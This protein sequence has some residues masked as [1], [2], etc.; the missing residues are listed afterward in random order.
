MDTMSPAPWEIRL[1]S[2]AESEEWNDFVCRR[3]RNA[4]FLFDRNYMDYHADR[5][6][7]HSMMAYRGGKLLALLPANITP[8][9]ILHSHQ[10][11]TYGGWVTSAA[12]FD[13]NDMM[14]MWRVWLDV[15]RREGIKGVDYKPLPWIFARF[16]AQE[17]L[18]M[19][20]R[21]GACLTES[22]LS[23]AVD[24]RDPRGFNTLQRRHLRQA[25]RLGCEI[26]YSDD[27]APFWEMLSL[28]LAERHGAS[29][30]HTAAELRLLME[31]FPD[32]IRIAEA[33]LDDELVAGV[34]LYITGT[35]VHAQ[36]IASTPRGREAN[37]LALLFDRVM[38]EAA[39]WG[40]RYFDFGTSNED[41]GRY[42]NSGLL[43]QKA[44]YGASGVTF[45]RW[46]LTPGS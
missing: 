39:R 4:T 26:R 7:D 9:G 29:P 42:L 15:C 38:A 19:L 33:R 27:C 2:P 40:K 16:P 11:L 17:D 14:D 34:C 13:A 35:A 10:G 22:N 1:Y 6:A 5:F 46:A 45:D 43:R 3:A 31:R 44:S 25:S 28:C 20:F 8:D 32:N 36:Y 21:S 37:A 23:S 12:H 30:V 18:Y 24:L 41:H